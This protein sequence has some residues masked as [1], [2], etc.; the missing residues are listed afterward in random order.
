M[1]HAE[2]LTPDFPSVWPEITA[3][4]VAAGKAMGPQPGLWLPFSFDG[5][6]GFML[7]TDK[8]AEQA[9]VADVFARGELTEGTAIYRRVH[10]AVDGTT[11]QADLGFIRGRRKSEA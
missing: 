3:E 2:P 11:H 7:L 4:L 8:L 6:R 1:E 10:S 9:F 5:G